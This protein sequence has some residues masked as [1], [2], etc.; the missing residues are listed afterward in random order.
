MRRKSWG[1]G[2]IIIPPHDF[3]HPPNWYY[4]AQLV[5][6]YTF[7]II[8]Y[9][10]KSVPNF[11]KIRT[12]IIKILNAHKRVLHAKIK[13]GWV[14]LVMRMRRGPWVLASSSLHLTISSNYYVGIIG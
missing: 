6:K 7:G 3:K 11:M 13:L 14:T 5:T 1:N 2:V 12:E 4:R 9:G 8:T 10:M